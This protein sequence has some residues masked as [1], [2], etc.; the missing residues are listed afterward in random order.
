MRVSYQGYFNLAAIGFLTVLSGVALATPTLT[1]RYVA[2]SGTVDDNS[3]CDAPGYV[4]AS[5]I[6][7]A[8][9]AAIA[10]DIVHICAGSYSITSTLLIDK[11]LTI[12]GE[13]AS[14]TTLDGGIAVQILR[15]LDSAPEESGG[16]PSVTITDLTFQNGAANE[17]GGEF[18]NEGR[19][20]GG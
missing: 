7:D 3:S 17:A 11:S 5:G 15:V 8:I 19:S 16:E 12:E 2:A 10:G 9:E 14:T 13:S 4:G 18:C 20:S 1:T 6:A